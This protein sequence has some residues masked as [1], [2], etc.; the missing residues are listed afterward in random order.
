MREIFRPDSNVHAFLQKAQENGYSMDDQLVDRVISRRIGGEL[1]RNGFMRDLVEL[2]PTSEFRQKGM[3]NAYLLHA[4]LNG[5]IARSTMDYET[6]HLPLFSVRVFQ[7]GEHGTTIHRNH[8]SIGPWAIGVTLSGSAPF[9]VYAQNQLPENTVL[10]LTGSDADPEPLETM[11]A[12]TGAA[13]TLYTSDELVPHSSGIV[14]EPHPRQL[15]IMYGLE[16]GF[17]S[18]DEYYTP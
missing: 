7:P 10:P 11:E 18:E 4:A 9:N 16:Y 5:A 2:K 6:N 8:P 1:T 13:W 17:G 3:M 12:T 15:L 14:R